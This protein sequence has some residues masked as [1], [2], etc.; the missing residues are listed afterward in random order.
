MIDLHSHVLPGVD[1]GA[2][3]E[4]T[5]AAMCRIAAADG[6]RILVATPHFNAALGVTDPARVADAADRL[7]RRIADEGLELELRVAAEMPLSENA[8]EAYRS[9]IWPAY[10]SG[11]CY[12]LLEMP[13]IQSGLPILQDVI[14]RL[15]MAGA[16]P[17]L[18]H[19]ERLEML[20]D[21]RAAEQVHQQGAVFQITASCLGAP[22]SRSGRRAIQWLRRGWVQVVASDA[23]DPVRRPPGLSAARHWLREHWGEDTADALT[24]VNPGKILNGEPL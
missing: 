19:P 11:R 6:I 2:S 15:R 1:D 4:D 5:A 13:P 14:F 16:T 20:E 23:H 21:L 7:K 9:G 8:V 12:V 17:V 3:D 18:A 24:R 22:D 10:D